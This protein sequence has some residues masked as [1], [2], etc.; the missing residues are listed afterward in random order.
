MSK[1]D[2]LT[3]LQTAKGGDAAALAARD[4]IIEQYMPA[5]IQVSRR[6][7]SDNMDRSD[8]ISEGVIGLIRA[9]EK[10]D[11]DQ[12]VS[13]LTYAKYW[14]Y[15]TM[16]RAVTS[17]RHL[18]KLPEHVTQGLQRLEKVHTAL[19]DTDL[20]EVS[21]LTLSTIQAA[22]YQLEVLVDFTGEPDTPHEAERE[23][24]F[25]T[26]TTFDIE[27]S[28]IADWVT[29]GAGGAATAEDIFLLRLHCDGMSFKDIGL[30]VGRT[31]DTVRRDVERILRR[32]RIKAEAVNRRG[33]EQG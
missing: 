14:V 30:I 13:F 23:A 33:H 21:G 3:L 1:E 4:R 9:I 26:S 22:R 28:A 15:S 20:E 25:Q 29:A 11:P 19:S 7:Y 2:G 18:V 27:C 31:K 8:I 17:N 12:N 6:L 5:V 32:I 10:F 16:M 24:V